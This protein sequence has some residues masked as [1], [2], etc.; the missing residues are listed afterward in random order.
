VELQ[1]STKQGTYLA[2]AL[3]TAVF[4][5]ASF[6]VLGGALSDP[7]TQSKIEPVS[8]VRQR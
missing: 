2:I 4:L 3:T 7:R 8:I 1:A 6:I 5:F